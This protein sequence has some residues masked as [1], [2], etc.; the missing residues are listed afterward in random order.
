MWALEENYMYKS[1][2]TFT[3]IHNEGVSVTL[4]GDEVVID[5]ILDDFRRFLLGAGFHPQ[6][7]ER[8]VYD[9]KD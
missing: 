7:V 5:D 3:F 8:I 1:G 2:Y 9:E 6:N 4:S